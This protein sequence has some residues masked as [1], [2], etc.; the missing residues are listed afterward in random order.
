MRENRNRTICRKIVAISPYLAALLLAG[1]CGS[2]P[3]TR[4]KLFEE[5][6]AGSGLDTYR[7]MTHGVAWGDF[8]GD[9]L[10][11]VY[12][13]NHLNEAQLFRN[14]GY[15]RFEEV[16][17]KLFSKSDLGGDKHG[18]AWAD[19]DNDGRLDLVQLTGAVRGAGEEPKRLFVNQGSR[20]EETAERLGVSNPPGRTRMPLWLDLDHDGRLDLFQGAESRFD[21]LTPPFVF[22][23]HGNQFA[24]AIDAL[25]LASRSVPF[26][27]LT[28]LTNGGSTDMLC[29]VAGK[30]VT[31]QVFDTASLPA[32]QLD[33]LPV[34]AF[35]DA[36]TGD[37]DN[38]G[39]I[40]VF[41]ARKNPPGPIAIGQPSSDELIVDV[42]IGGS[43]GEQAAGITFRTTG[44]VNYEI[45]PMEPPG[46]LH[47]ASVHIGGQ[48]KH[49]DELK[50]ALSPESPDIH[51]TVPPLPG[52]AG[53]YL[54]LLSKDCWEV[55][56]SPG[57]AD[58]QASSH[59]QIALRI[60]SDSPINQV[61]AAG[62]MIRPEEAA[63]RLLM[64][65]NG[66]LVEEGDKRGIN[67]RPIAAVN[68]VAGD[69]DNDMNLDLFLVGSGDVGKQSNMLLRNLGRG[70]F[71]VIELAGGAAG[72][73]TGVGDSVTA[74]DFD[75]D[76]F[77]DLLV[78]SG[79][80]MGRS[81]GF[82]SAQGSYHLYRNVGNANHWLEID[83]EGTKSNRD[84]IGARVQ[85]AV[86]GIAQTRLQDGGIH[87]RGQ[88]HSRLH[89]G[90]GPH[91]LIDKIRVQWPSGVVQ[92]LVAVQT[93][94][95]LRI[96]EPMN[97]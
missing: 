92:E 49:P 69:F 36:A 37:F 71:E 21:D 67:K 46:A 61:E 38:D 3:E 23:H 53:V 30:G 55:K 72:P 88:N 83:L 22:L 76:G 17:A 80:S 41:L 54:G 2:P 10:P 65:R 58:P 24:P 73:M 84:G 32:R 79:G 95:I 8:D 64:N 59:L 63:Q 48:G 5:V 39:L 90:L 50:F 82:S 86:A 68:V 45:A 7:G 51:G 77:L 35:E 60:D 47:A 97:P 78:A 12:V 91:R 96:R 18:A 43:E 40:D 66:K 20:F 85:V 70:Q 13:T 44:K 4:I 27:L 16:S 42:S 19:L 75:G 74:V 93:N 81:L 11:D 1:S 6:T 52:R 87:N 29:R 9:G 15:G 94:Q 14:L 57:T 28:G 26:C 89:F 33:L 31:A 62:G 34:S 25:H 56:V